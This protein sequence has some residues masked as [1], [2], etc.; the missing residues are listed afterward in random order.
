MS[1]AFPK[2]IKR[3]LQDINKEFHLKSVSGVGD[4]W[5]LFPIYSYKEKFQLMPNTGRESS[6]TCKINNPYQEQYLSFTVEIQG[7]SRVSG[8]TI[9]TSETSY[10]QI[11]RQLLP[12]EIAKFEGL[13]NVVFYSN[14]WQ[15]FSQ[16]DVD[17]SQIWVKSGYQD[18]EIKG[19]VGDN[20]SDI[21]I[22]FRTMGPPIRLRSS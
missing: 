9:G 21:H 15:K 14:Q 19:Q 4:Q 6:V 11:E 18:I 2:E 3:D 22:E 1:G 16:Q 12:G 8:L 20:M 13:T 17:P 10:I 7:D 5:D